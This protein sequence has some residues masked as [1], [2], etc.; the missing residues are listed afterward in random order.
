MLAAG[1][2]TFFA[3]Q[4][5]N[6]QEALILKNV[7]AIARN[8]NKYQEAF[9]KAYN[10]AYDAIYSTVSDRCPR[11]T[12]PCCDVTATLSIPGWASVSVTFYFYKEV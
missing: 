5:M 1:T 4:P 6:A 8:E 10:T 3:S 11:G 12:L 2:V 9:S 7:E